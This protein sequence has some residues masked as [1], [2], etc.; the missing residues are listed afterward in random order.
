MA[1]I[2]E[3]NYKEIP[4]KVRKMRDAANEINGE[5]V[6]SYT[7]ISAMKSN[8]HGTRY[9][10]LAKKCNSIIPDINKLLKL[11]VTDIPFALEQVANN[12]SKAD[13]GSKIVSE[14][15]IASRNIPEI[16]M[17]TEETMK[18]ITS[19]VTNV[20]NAVST[21]FTK[22]MSKLDEYQNVFNSINWNSE[23]ADIFK[24]EFKA[25]KVKVSSALNDI[26]ELFTT[27]MRQASEDIQAAES[28]NTLK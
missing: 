22:T 26:Q 18:F 6:N 28:G 1:R 8:W 19:E 15:Q 16:T 12:Y 23:A 27:L 20:K 3:V 7:K 25:A 14:Q 4:S 2:Q 9:N 11:V 13:R 17:T 10:E 5:I 24:R 21:S